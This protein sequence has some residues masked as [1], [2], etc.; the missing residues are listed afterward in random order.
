MLC[1]APLKQTFAENT[2][3][4]A[5]VYSA[6]T[7]LNAAKNLKYEINLYVCI[8][9]TGCTICMAP[10]FPLQ[11]Q[12][13]KTIVPKNVYSLYHGAS[14]YPLLVSFCLQITEK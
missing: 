6:V 12:S 3:L 9:K 5:F 11:R 14:F 1:S 2:N 7:L 4:I 13:Y 10:K 8:V